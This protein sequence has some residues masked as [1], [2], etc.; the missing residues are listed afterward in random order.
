MKLYHYDHCPY[1]VRAR[2]IIGWKGL[3][4]EEEILAN[5]DEQSHY[6]L[7]GA[8]IVPILKKDDGSY[9]TESLDIVDY[10][11]KNYGQVLLQD[12]PAD[13]QDTKLSRWLDAAAEPARHLVH[14]RNIR[15]FQQDFPARADRDYYET[16]KSR[17]IG[18]FATAFENSAGYIAA[19]APLLEELKPLLESK[20]L[21]GA[22]PDYAD[23]LLFPIL[24]SL[25]HVEG[26][27][28]PAEVRSYMERIGEE[29]KVAL[30]FEQAI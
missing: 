9:M 30:L 17:S 14:P 16:K 2:M 1:C 10:I 24:R 23:I 15:I 27:I 11:D 12:N 8:K 21:Q 26:L 4:V 28:F 18:S 22:T 20:A 25:S 6:D 29:T 7:V 5:A 19:L 3:N 13:Y